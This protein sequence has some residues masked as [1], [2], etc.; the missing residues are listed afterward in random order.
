[1]NLL[2]SLRHLKTTHLPWTTFLVEVHLLLAQLAQE[3]QIHLAS[4]EE[5][6]EVV[7]STSVSQVSQRNLLELK[8]LLQN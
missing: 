7:D 5:T 1:M 4:E 2:P 6:R 3:A 8:T